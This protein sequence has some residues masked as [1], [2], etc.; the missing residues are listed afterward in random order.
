[1]ETVIGSGFSKAITISSII[2][3]D[4]EETKTPIIEFGTNT[5]EDYG[6]GSIIEEQGR[7]QIADLQGVNGRWHDTTLTGNLIK[8]R[9]TVSAHINDNTATTTTKLTGGNLEFATNDGYI[10]HITPNKIE[11]ASN[12]LGEYSHIILNL[13]HSS[14]LDELVNG[15]LYYTDDGT[16]KVKK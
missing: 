12:L 15:E 2:N 5:T 4:G 13:P 1:M 9:T 7:I 11:F 10:A 3:V 8:I 6:G 16:I 14:K